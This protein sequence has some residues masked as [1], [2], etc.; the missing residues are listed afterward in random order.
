M[1]DSKI[2]DTMKDKF[3]DLKNTNVKEA[4]KDTY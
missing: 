4:V 3:E 1:K 2:V